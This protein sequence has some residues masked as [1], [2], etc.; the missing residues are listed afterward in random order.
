MKNFKPGSVGA[1]T[2]GPFSDF[3]GVVVKLQPG[4]KIVVEVEILGRKAE[5]TLNQE[6]FELL[7][8]DPRPRFRDEI[9]K[10]IDQMLQEEFDNWWLKQ[11][12]RPEDDLVAEW[13]A[14]CAFRQEFEAKAAVERQTLLNAFEASFTAIAEHGVSWAKQ[15][16]ETETERW[17][18]NA[19]RH[20]EFYKAA[21]QQIKECP[22]DSGHW[23]DIWRHLWQAANERSWKAEY[24]AW[25][26]E[27]LPDA[28]TIEQMR[29]DARQK[30][31]ALVER[32]RSLVQQTHGLTLPDHVF[33]FWAFWL[34]L[35]PIERQE[36]HWI[37][38]PCGLF[39]L[40]SEEGLQRKPIPELDHRL[41]YRYYRDPPEFL[42]LLYGG[43]DGLHFGL[44]Y[45][46][47][48]ELP[49]G[50][51]YYWNNDGIP[52][53]DDGCQTLLQQVRFQIE[54]AVSQLEY[55][56]YDNDSRH[57]RVRLS[58]L[59]D[60]VMAFETA[61]RPEMGSLY[62]KAY[63]Q[64]RL[65]ARIATEDGAGVAIP[66]F[67]AETFP[68]RDLEVIRIAIL[69]DAPIVQDWI[70]AAL[71]ACAE[72]QP[73]EALAFG[74]DLHWL[75]GGNP[76]R[77]AAAAKLLDAAYRALGRD[78]LAAI[79]FVHFQKRSLQSVNIY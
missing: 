73:A 10:D 6:Q 42:T 39:D 57:R 11:L 4:E 34:S 77:E 9:E 59:R 12:D 67:S 61:E 62:E 31:Q 32:V 24:M 27:N 70:V 76:E 78:A 25:R 13:S 45:D 50:V 51:M 40:F 21:R 23:T 15:R 36:M 30:A 20:E 63:K 55:D 75:S 16:W 35:T 46:D 37:A 44:W 43:G 48:R 38:T 54:K 29:L 68:Q 49:T 58:A 3:Q 14:F 26:Q 1:I 28:A 17:T 72:G 64:Q 79:A 60:A 18:P 52:V 47:P 19:Y 7:G 5:I 69:G 66:G 22:D 56:R 65:G 53:C 71:E 8:E 2:A 41:H 74:R 33:A